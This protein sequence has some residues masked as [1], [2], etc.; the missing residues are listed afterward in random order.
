MRKL[1]SLLALCGL[2]F[3]GCASILNPRFQKVAIKTAKGSK[4]TINGDTPKKKDGKYYIKRGRDPQQIVITKDG[5]QDEY[6]AVVAHRKSPLFFVSLGLPL[7]YFI[8]PVGGMFIFG[9]LFDYGQKSMNYDKAYDFSKMKRDLYEKEDNIKDVRLNQVSVSV[10]KK[11]LNYDIFFNYKQYLKG[12][13]YYSTHNPKKSIKIERE[14]I[15]IEN[16]VFT[17]MLNSILHDKG[18]IN[19]DNKALNSSYLNNVYLN[20][21]LV[22]IDVDVINSNAKLSSGKFL[23]A[24]LKIEWEI[25]DYYK[26]Q[27]YKRTIKANSGQIVIPNNGEDAVSAAFFIASSDAISRSLIQ[28]M[29]FKEVKEHIKVSEEQ[30]R[31]NSFPVLNIPVASQYVSTMNEAINSSVTIKNEDGHGSGFIISEN[32]YIITNYHVISDDSKPLEV[33]MN[34]GDTFTPEITRVDK[35]NDL[36]LLKINAEGLIPYKISA[37]E[38][39]EIAKEIYAVGTP[40]AE[41]LGSTV[42]KGIISGIRKNKSGQKILQTDAS[43]NGGNSGGVICTKEGLA[44]GVV[45]SKLRG[46]GIEGVAFGI[47]SYLIFEK[48]KINYTT[49]EK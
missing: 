35:V 16:T 4:L 26:K 10:D 49:V 45:S 7:T 3:G 39:I 9:A 1:I 29:N 2:L 34:N 42:S 46:L 27:I 44:L 14:D 33:V 36:A 30:L 31:E 22:E 12:K 17:D 48:L 47:P 25:L 41:D 13:K 24:T 15:D 19:K 8:N 43:I 40:T 6:H 18:F 23:N 20:A 38:E 11:K 37:S 28:F 32:G 21:N 5:Y